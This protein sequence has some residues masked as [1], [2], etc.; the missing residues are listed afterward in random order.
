MAS[1]YIA[2]VDFQSLLRSLPK[3]TQADWRT[4]A[5]RLLRGK[6]IDDISVTDVGGALD[7]Y[8]TTEGY[9]SRL[10]PSPRFGWTIMANPE[11]A[12]AEVTAL[13]LST[14]AQGL[15]LGRVH[16]GELEPAAFTSVRFDF[17]TTCFADFDAARAVVPQQLRAD[18]AVWLQGATPEA[19]SAL[20]HVGFAP[21]HIATL[22]R[23]TTGSHQLPVQ[24]ALAQLV[25][26]LSETQKPAQLLPHIVLRMEVPSDYVQAI[27][28]LTAMRLL[29]ANVCLSFGADEPVP[30][31]R[32]Y[33]QICPQP[34]ATA[35][36]YLV[37]A[38]ARSVAAVSAGVEALSVEPFA[39]DPQ[40]LRR[41][42]TLQQVLALEGNFA[43]H[44]D[45]VRGAAF[46]ETAAVELAEAAWSNL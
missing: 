38:A 18:S 32:I 11:S 33:G 35:E 37:D 15:D 2:A 28:Q 31:C 21:A 41:S 13:A 20:A 26:Y 30:P 10:L 3:S 12:T 9:R 5:E 36:G 14:G 22:L 46:V 19:L 16:V 45:A 27:V 40:Q 43:M 23:A 44:G 25:D 17:L 6:T 8:A 34:E 24:A 4:A 39:G 7:P 29:W 1:E 42:I